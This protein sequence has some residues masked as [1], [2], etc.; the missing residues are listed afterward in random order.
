MAGRVR[1]CAAA[2][3]CRWLS[4]AAVVGGNATRPWLGGYGHRVTGAE[5]PS[6]R[7]PSAT[8]VGRSLRG[9]APGQYPLSD[10]RAGWWLASAVA[11][12][13][14]PVVDCPPPVSTRPA[15]GGR[16]GCL[17]RRPIAACHGRGLHL[18]PAPTERNWF[19]RSLRDRT[20]SVPAQPWA[21]AMVGCLGAPSIQLRSA[22]G[23]SP[24]DAAF[25]THY[26]G[27]RCPGHPACMRL[28]R[29]PRRLSRRTSCSRVRPR[30]T[31]LQ[32]PTPPLG[33]LESCRPSVLASPVPARCW[34]IERC[35][36]GS[37]GR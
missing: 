2:R 26:R 13:T 24:F 36:R 16:D 35:G 25:A 12:R 15:M 6:P 32:R 7:P 11:S 5:R 19:S 3:G 22:G 34:P 33:A 20:G 18:F 37:F 1:T 30:P 4:A 21:G 10:G 14:P 28:L 8:G 31:A 9:T 29:P 23:V 27:G 17:P